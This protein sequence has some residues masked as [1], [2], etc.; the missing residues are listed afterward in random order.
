MYTSAASYMLSAILSRAADVTLHDYLKPRIFE[1]MGIEGESWDLGP[2]GIN[3]GGNGLTARTADLLK[4]G[5]LHAQGGLWEGRRILPEAWVTEST[6][7][8]GQEA[9]SRYGYHWAIRPKGAFS[10]LGI[11][12]Q[13]VL[14]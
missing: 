14:V 7:P 6:R 4:L 2:D 9:G 10:A 13:A 3:P 12:V 1:P 5:I 8:Q 11:F